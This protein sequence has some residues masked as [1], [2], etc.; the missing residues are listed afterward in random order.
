MTLLRDFVLLSEVQVKQVAAFIQA[1]WEAC[2]RD[3]KPIQV[4]VQTKH[5]KRS[6]AQ[7]RRLHALLR[8]ISEQ[9]WFNG[10]KYDEETWKEWF[11]RK[12]IGTEEIIMPDGKRIERGISTTILS[13]S[14]FTFFMDQIEAW[15]VTE[16]GVEFG[17]W[18]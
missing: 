13:V 5:V 2:A 12:F 3:K 10:R 11:R 4:I 1:N 9:A 8:D 6:S 15:A 17:G 7:N 14:E 16:M 18:L